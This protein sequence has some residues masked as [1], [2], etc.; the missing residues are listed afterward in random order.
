MGEDAWCPSL[1]SVHAFTTRT[2]THVR[3]HWSTCTHTQITKLKRIKVGEQS[4]EAGS[5]QEHR[6][7]AEGHWETRKC[8]ESPSAH[9]GRGGACCFPAH[10][11]PRFLQNCVACDSRAANTRLSRAFF[12]PTATP[13]SGAARARRTVCLV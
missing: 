10:V 3:T 6:V 4:Q 13:Q 1:V 5:V 12:S 11:A 7:P 9:D 2:Y 8:P